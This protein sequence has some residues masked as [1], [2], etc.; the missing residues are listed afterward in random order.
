MLLGCVTALT[1]LA[2]S[3]AHAGIFGTTPINISIGK[4]QTAPNGASGEPAVSG[5]NRRVKLIAYSSLASNLVNGDSNGVRDVFVW[6]RPGGSVP[7]ELGRGYLRRV[8]IGRHGRQANG[9]SS[10]PSV[11]GSMTRRPRC[12][13]FQSTA[14]NISQRDALPDSDIYVRDLRRRRTILVS[15]GVKGGATNP[16]LSGNCR[17][18]LF[19][20]G[21][22]VYRARVGRGRAKQLGRGSEPDYSR[23]GRSITFVRADGHVVFLHGDRQFRLGRGRS[24]HVSDYATGHGWAVAYNSDGNVMLGLINRG[25]KSIQTAVHDGI[26]GGITARAAGRGIVVWARSS[27]LFYL[28]RHTGNSDDLA[29]SSRPITEID[30]SARANLIAFAAPGDSGFKDVPG[31]QAQ[32][33]YVKWLPK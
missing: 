31:N 28:N 1:L 17:K 15:V 20:A 24:P 13:A 19:E 8:S 10:D 16:A 23:D 4:G 25:R 33:V 29:Y 12:V 3:D 11:D 18:V 22:K 6:R 30:S 9:P 26:V 32:S 5:D 14:T 7:R 2:T 27:A 21:G